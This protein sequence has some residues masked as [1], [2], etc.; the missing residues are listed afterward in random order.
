[1]AFAAWMNARP[2][3]GHL[4]NNLRLD[5]QVICIRHISL[6]VEDHNV[7]DDRRTEEDVFS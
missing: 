3:L 1:M 7:K 2:E 5:K 6:N 4:C